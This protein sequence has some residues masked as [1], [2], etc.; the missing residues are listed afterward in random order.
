MK[1]QIPYVC[2]DHNMFCAM[3]AYKSFQWVALIHLA[4]FVASQPHA[5]HFTL[6]IALVAVL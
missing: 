6:H 1:Q 3:H 4:G 5:L 2:V